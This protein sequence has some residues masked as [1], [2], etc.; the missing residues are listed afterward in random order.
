MARS[1]ARSWRNRRS[2]IDARVRF[3]SRAVPRP[4]AAPADRHRHRGRR[5][6]LARAPAALR[7]AR[8]RRAVAL[9]RSRR[10]RPYSRPRS[11]ICISAKAGSR[12]RRRKR[13]GCGA[14]SPPSPRSPVGGSRHAAR[15]R[16]GAVRL[17]AGIA[18]LVLVSITG[19]YGGNLTHGTTFLGEYAPSFLRSL[20]R[21]GAAPAA[22]RRASPPPIRISTS[23]S[24]CS[25][26]AAAR[27]TTTTSA[28]AAS[29]SAATT[30]RSSA[31]TRAARSCPATSKRASSSTASGLPPDDEAFMP[32][33]GK[34]PLTAEQVE[35]LRW[36]VGAGAPR[37]TTVGAIGVPGRRRAAA[38]RAARARRRSG[39][40]R[41]PLPAAPRPIRSSSPTC[42]QP[43]C[44]CARYRRATRV[45]SSASSSP[46]TALERRSARGARTPPRPRSST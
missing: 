7:G 31:A 26:S 37:D 9:G 35:I 18:M 24:R 32:A 10:S 44:S 17:A 3:F 45:S 28:T 41:R 8:E 5:A 20:D 21:R 40:G 36:W 46:G 16:A 1:C 12:G 22:G 14:R 11:A 19:H 4:R 27:A 43:G 42:S 6:R 2:P 33:E 39:D 13:T 34:T 38:R 30:R 23:C 15:G 25:S 29:A